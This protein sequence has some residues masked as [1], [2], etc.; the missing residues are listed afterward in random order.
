[1]LNQ[2]TVR[3]RLNGLGQDPY[4]LAGSVRLNLDP[5]QDLPK[6][7]H[8]N[9]KRLIRALD[10]VQLWSLVKQNGGL[11]VDLKKESLSHGQRQLFCIARALLRPGKVV[12]LDEINSR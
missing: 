6:S 8:S 9:D 5:Y 2:E 11:D 4:F 10:A 3:S 1:M 7:D 12:V